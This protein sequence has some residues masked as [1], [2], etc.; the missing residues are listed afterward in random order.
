MVD[1]SA[2]G[3]ERSEFLNT[4]LNPV[5]HDL[6]TEIIVSQPNE[7]LDFMVEWLEK[8]HGGKS[9][10]KVDEKKLKTIVK[11]D[12]IQDLEKE[13]ALLQEELMRL[14]NK[15]QENRQHEKEAVEPGKA[16][17]NDDDD[18]DDDV[19]LDEVPVVMKPKAARTSVSAEAYGAWNKKTDFKPPVYPKSDEQS[20]R[21]SELL[22][23]SF[24]FS[25][26]DDSA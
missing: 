17:A 2:L 25:S 24:L 11:S 8:K 4:K 15:L 12:K 14:K 22:N 21:L 18:E 20:G 10:Y 3:P 23:K 7:P 19:L 9:D 6:V 26:C 13:N 1:T 16:S 5:L